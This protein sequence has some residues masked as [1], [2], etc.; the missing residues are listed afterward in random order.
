MTG[1]GGALVVAASAFAQECPDAGTAP[2]P[3]EV[4]VT[5][6]PIVVASTTDDYFVLYV[7]HEV[8]ADT[9]VHIPVS[10][11][12]GETGSTTLAEHVEALPAARYKVEKYASIADP[13]DVDGDCTDDLTEL[14]NLGSQSP[15][16]S[17][18]D[19]TITNGAVAVP[20]RATFDTLSDSSIVK[21]LM[22]G[23]DTA[24]PT[25][26]FIN[27]N[28]H[29]GSCRLLPSLRRRAPARADPRRSYLQPRPPCLQR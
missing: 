14:D 13:A 15:V 17:A 27:T 20:D 9:T 1:L 21:F 7:S 6:V 4:A 24:R 3:T 19:L 11:T 5:A 8:D 23:L 29:S 12:R 10:V 25:L 2:T 28:T 16:N 18:P 22:F 26:Y